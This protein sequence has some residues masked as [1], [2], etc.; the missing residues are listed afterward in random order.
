MEAFMLRDAISMNIS[1]LAVDESYASKINQSYMKL[2]LGKPF[3]SDAEVGYHMFVMGF[4]DCIYRSFSFDKQRAFAKLCVRCGKPF[5]GKTMKKKHCTDAC[6]WNEWK[7]RQVA[8][9]LGEKK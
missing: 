8:E 6:K 5:V 2:H 4:W 9:K 1:E 3:F 7:D